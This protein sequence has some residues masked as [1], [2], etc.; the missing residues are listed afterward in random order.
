M[1]LPPWDSL[2]PSGFS[3]RK[4][5]PW[6]NAVFAIRAHV[7]IWA[8]V[9]AQVNSMS[10]RKNKVEVTCIAMCLCLLFQLPASAAR[11]GK[12]N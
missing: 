2:Y 7:C 11:L 3:L 4:K 5:G 12:F 8:A 9:V 6:I 1:S 10:V